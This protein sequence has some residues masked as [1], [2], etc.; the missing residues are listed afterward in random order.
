MG[1][2]YSYEE[3]TKAAGRVQYERPHEEA[4]KHFE[5]IAQKLVPKLLV[6]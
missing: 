3:Y 6:K 2:P 4:R 5:H 1:G